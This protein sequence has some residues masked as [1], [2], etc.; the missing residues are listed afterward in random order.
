MAHTS[1]TKYLSQMYCY[2][3]SQVYSTVA[4]R[5]SILNQI[6]WLTKTRSDSVL[7]LETVA[8]YSQQK[9]ANI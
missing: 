4:V 3:F 5:P 6:A 7:S 9:S 1:E 2:A 8:M